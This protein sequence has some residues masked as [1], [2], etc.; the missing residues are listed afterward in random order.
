MPRTANTRPTSR[1]ARAIGFAI[2]LCALTVGVT[3]LWT[4]AAAAGGRSKRVVL[5]A[6]NQTLGRT[7]LTTRRGLT[8]YSLSVERH[9]RFVCTGSCLSTWHPL[10]IR[11]GVKPKGPV[12][13]GTV[14]RPDGRTHVVFRGRPLY[15]FTGD[16]KKGEAN[17]EGFKDVGTWRA[18][19]VGPIGQPQPEPAYPPY[20][21]AESPYPH[22]QTEPLPAPP[23]PEP[24]PY[25]YAQWAEP[26]SPR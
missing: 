3:Q 24:P 13:L 10:V 9:G 25:P 20:P 1:R 6:P 11:K 12:K 22:P 16:S 7:V 26:E 21:P 2:C 14:R 15:S 8:L 5:K 4:G 17:G 18:A 19:S 23:Q